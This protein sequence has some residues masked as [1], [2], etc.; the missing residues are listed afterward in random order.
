MT[1]PVLT[2]DDIRGVEPGSVLPVPPGAIVTDLAREVAQAHRISLVLRDHLTTP[3]S[4][5][6]NGSVIA[7]G[8]D[9]GPSFPMKE[10]LKPYLAELGY[11]ILDCGTFT[12][13]AVDYP[14]IAYAVAKQVANSAAWRGIIIDG[15]GIG[16]CMAANKV[17]GIRAALCYNEAMARNSREHN[18]ANVLTM[19]AGM[20]GLNLARQIVETW[21]KSDFGGGRHQRRVNKI[22]EIE[23][24]FLK[25]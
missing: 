8:A 23:Q 15:A 2:V 25:G 4:T 20:I 14:D 6:G 21:L 16:S 11:T 24:R 12:P 13:D 17:P 18:D 1:K 7:I 3:A 22:V 9:H 10:A 19:G 5:A